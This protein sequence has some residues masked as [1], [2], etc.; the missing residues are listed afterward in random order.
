MRVVGPI[1]YIEQGL[2]AAIFRCQNKAHLAV[3]LIAL[4]V[5]ELQAYPSAVG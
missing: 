1:V 2:P 4:L 3:V 5:V